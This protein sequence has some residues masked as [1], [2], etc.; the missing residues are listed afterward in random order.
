[1]VP[2]WFVVGIA[3]VSG[4]ACAPNT[5]L[6]SATPA[7]S[8]TTNA[9][10]LRGTLIA[11][12][13]RENTASLIDLA[14]GRTVKKVPTGPNPQE[15]AISP[16]GKTVVVSDMGTP[17]SPGKTLTVFTL[18]RAEAVRKIEL[19]EH[20]Q[21]HGLVWLDDKRVLMTSHDTNSVLVV[22]VADGKIEM[23]V[24]TGQRGTHLALPSPDRKRAYASNVLDGTVSVIDLEAG[25]ILKQ[26]PSG[27]RAEGIALSPDGKRLAVGNLGGASVTIIDTEKLEA[28]Q[29]LSGTPTPIRTYF[30]PDGKRLLVSC[31]EPGRIA[32]FD[33]ATY[34]PLES[35]ELAK[36]E[37]AL[38]LQ[39]G[40]RLIPMNWATSRDKRHLFVVMVATDTVAILDA[41]TLKVIGHVKTGSLPDGIDSTPVIAEG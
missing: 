11:L 35:I 22:Q 39:P 28:I 38:P 9:A 36:V 26:I 27:T 4:L 1:M 20:G 41:A 32:V 31:A 6:E 24:G 13:K 19:G 3:F 8:A 30:T 2:S 21:P 16:D 5:P 37:P 23:V 18:P 10:D 33:A 40:G 15:V 17:P 25:K 34:E 14:S 12:N 7:P 29:T